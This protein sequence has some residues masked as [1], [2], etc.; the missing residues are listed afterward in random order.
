LLEDLARRGDVL[1]VSEDVRVTPHELRGDVAQRL[2]DGE[3]PFVCSDLREKDAFEQ[4]VSNLAAEVVVVASIDRVQHFVRF[5]QHERSKRLERLLAIP[6]TTARTAQTTH[7]VDELLKR[8]AS[9]R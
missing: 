3:S 2:G 1:R 6:W 7:H 5:F 9:V 8:L 4:Q